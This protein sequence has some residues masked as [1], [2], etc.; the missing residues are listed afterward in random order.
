MPIYQYIA[1][2]RASGQKINGSIDAASEGAGVAVLKE[3]GLLVTSIK[4]KKAKGAA[5]RGGRGRRIGIDD[6][7]I[8]CRQ[9]ATIVNAGL[10]LIEGLNILGEQMENATF[11]KIVK[12][13][14]KDVEGGDTLTDSLARHPKVFSGLFVNLVK[15]GEAS[16]MLDEILAQLALYLEKASSLQR[17]VKSAMIYPSVVMTVAVAVVT[18]LMVFVI[19]VFEK[20]FQGFGAKLPTPTLVLLAISH[21]IR[22]YWYV[23]V[24]VIFAVGFL[25]NRYLKTERGRYQFDAMLLRLPILGTLFRKVAVAK[26]SRT[27]STLLRAGVNILVAL[28]IVAKTAGNKVVERAIDNMRS[29]IKEGESV[30]GPLKESG[31]F[32]PMV[33]RMID[34][35][36]RTGALDEMLTKIAD[37]YEDQVDTAVAGLTQMLEPFILVFLGVIVGGILIAMYMPMFKITTVIKGKG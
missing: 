36:E 5:K 14:E 11:R 16:G 18:I 22:D 3:R 29:S 23:L 32:P 10:P 30:A 34:I 7:V 26:F 9:L 4:T 8:F 28:E 12:Q 15:A 35:G 21:F 17:K 20:I 27:F 13:I 31:V 25:I 19:P 33:T 24:G 37:F 2:N 1:L 6:L